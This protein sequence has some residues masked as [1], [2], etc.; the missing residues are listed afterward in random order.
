M[1][2]LLVRLLVRIFPPAFSRMFGDELERELLALHEALRGRRRGLW[3]FWF[4]P[5]ANTV[6]RL[7]AEWFDALSVPSTTMK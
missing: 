4:G 2:R 6:W 7:I 3:L 5:L 1:T